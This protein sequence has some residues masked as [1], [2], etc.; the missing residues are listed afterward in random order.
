MDHIEEKGGTFLV[1]VSLLAA[2]TGV[3][4]AIVFSDNGIYDSDKKLLSISLAIAFA[5]FMSGKKQQMRLI[6]KKIACLFIYIY[7]IMSQ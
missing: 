6:I 3:M 7:H 4:M 1:V 2:A 5:L